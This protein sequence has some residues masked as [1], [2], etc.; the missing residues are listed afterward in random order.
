MGGSNV[1]YIEASRSPFHKR[2]PAMEVWNPQPAN[3]T[4]HASRN[5]LFPRYQA[6]V[7]RVGWTLL[8]RPSTKMYADIA[9]KP[10]RSTMKATTPKTTKANKPPEMDW[11]F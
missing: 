10:N 4:T 9:N 2:R 7:C 5:R 8:S 6:E 1:G 3:A 11:L